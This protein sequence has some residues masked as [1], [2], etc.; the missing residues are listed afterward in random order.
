MPR[1]VSRYYIIFACV[2]FTLTSHRIYIATVGLSKLFQSASPDDIYKLEFYPRF[3]ERITSETKI[4]SY[5][6]VAPT[7]SNLRTLDESKLPYQCGIIFFYHIACTGGSSMNR[8][9]GK[10]K[11]NNENVTYWT[12]WGRHDGVQDKFIIGMEKQVKDLAPQQW[13]I[14]HAHGFS[15]FPNTSEPYLYQWREEV[16]RQGCGFV[17]TTMLRD[18]I[19]HTISQSKGMINPNYTLDT[20]V[21]HLEPENYNQRG[22]FNTQID[23]LVYNRGPRNQ[24]NAT[25]EEKVRRAM[26]LLQRHFDVVLLSD[27]KRFTEIILKVTGWNPVGMRHANVFNGELNFTERE[28]NKI[29]TLTEANGDVLLID[30][31]KHIYYGHLDYL[32]V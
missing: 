19:G 29:K 32:L 7:L 6:R 14:V 20:Y 5:P 12:H 27:Y 8:W 30:A 9:L 11:D 10:E 4:A 23:Y 15:L 24:H 25:K 13:R 17:M 26:E 21:N 2:L 22:I 16:E 31:V 3:S 28:L 18:A 1:R